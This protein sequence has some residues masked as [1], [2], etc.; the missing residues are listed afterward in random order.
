MNDS[1]DAKRQASQYP[2]RH[3]ERQVRSFVLRAGRMTDA[4]R[5]AYQQLWSSYGVSQADGALVPAELFARDAD[6]VLEIGFGMGDSLVDM[7]IAAPDQNFIGIEVHTPGVG[8]LM[9]RCEREK[10]SNIRVYQ[11][12]AVDV[13]ANCIADQ[14]LAKVQIFFPDPWHKKKHHKRRIVQPAFVQLLRQKLQPDGVLHLATDWQHYAEHMMEV[15]SAADGFENMQDQGEFAV[16]PEFR[17][18]TKFERRGVKLGH[19]V[20]DLLFQKVA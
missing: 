1:S 16:R 12:D 20:W 3:R 18:V 2:E 5:Q 15:M 9:H 4:Q 10:V 14:S 19:G 6:T 8:R 13:L 17:P 11:D 7:A